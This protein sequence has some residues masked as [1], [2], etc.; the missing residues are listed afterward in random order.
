MNDKITGIFAKSR[1]VT[2]SYQTKVIT[3]GNVVEIYQY[4]RPVYT[5]R[6][7]NQDGRGYGKS[8][9][10]EENRNKHVREIK[11]MIRRQ[12][13]SNYVAGQGRF[14]TLTHHKNEEDLTR[15]HRVFNGFIKEYTK[16][17]GFKLEYTAVIE[18]QERGSIHYHCIFYNLPK[19]VKLDDLRQLWAVGSVNVKRLNNVDNVGAYLTGYF[20]SA[21]SRL[22][23]RK[24]Y[25]C[26]KGLK[27]PQETKKGVDESVIGSYTH[28]G[29]SVKFANEYEIEETKNKIHYTQLIKK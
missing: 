18:F 23:G 21:E 28:Q 14:I 2:G 3:A 10:A 29:Y 6:S 9:S 4:D 27:K 26:S 24:A 11:K 1:N 5:G 16:Y 7:P 20:S 12:I 8:T 25:L 13:N 22:K 17:M 19:K 15:S